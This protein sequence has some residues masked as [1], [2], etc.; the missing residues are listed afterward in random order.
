MFS[1]N[2][3]AVWVG[4]IIFSGLF[5]LGQ[6]TWPP[7][8]DND[9]DGFS[10]EG[11]ECGPVDCDDTRIYVNPGIIE[12]GPSWSPACTDG[13]DNDCD[14][15]VDGEEEDCL[16]SISC[17]VHAD[18]NDGNPCTDEW[19]WHYW[20]A[21]ICMYPA[22]DEDGDGHTP[23]ECGGDDCDDTR[24]YVNPGIIEIGIGSPA[25]TDGVDNDCDGLI[26]TEDNECNE[27][28]TCQ[29]DED[30]NDENPC[31]SEAC[32]WW[33][34]LGPGY[35][36]I[37]SFD[38]D[39]D[40]HL[41][42]A[43]G[44]DDCDDTNA[45]VYPNAP[46]LC[47]GV[48][49]QCPGDPGYGEVDEVDI[50]EDGDGFIAEACGGDD[51]DDTNADIHPA[52]VDDCDNGIDD[53]CDGLVDDDD[54][55]DMAKI[56]AGCFDM[57]DSSDG[58]NRS[59]ECPVHN[60]CISAFE[61]DVH[62]VTNAEVAACVAGGGCFG[63]SQ[64]FSHSRA[65][66]YGDPAYD[67]F[68][69]IYMSWYKAEE[70]CAWA[71]KRLPTEA[72]WEYAARGGL[73][74]KRYPRG[75][76]ISSADANFMYSGDPWDNDTSPVEYYA[77]NGYG[78]YDMAGNVWE[79]VNDWWNSDYYQYCVDHGIVNDPPGPATGTNRVS[80]SGSWGQYPERLSV[81]A[82]SNVFVHS[83]FGYSSVGFRCAR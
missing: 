69:V 17:D 41:P 71:G 12:I 61:M 10:V 63:P 30:C 7:C 15:L 58:C 46:E 81:A 47:D 23:A 51:C 22:H 59:Y 67:D 21:G 66:Y 53:D 55:C 52:A 26:D 79:W 4:I 68:P 24:I 1:R 49:N 80:R 50:D 40:G 57:G 36:F 56:P 2:T 35:C 29:S 54:Y 37:I 42:G 77:P 48:D 18:C 45:D 3:F 72:E 5:L 34:P 33:D 73:S 44:G 64:R 38:G 74:G 78:L 31:T 14:G 60:V 25:C 76:T 8:T 32:I 62:E 65:T 75:D 11:G 27:A 16:N 39:L 83:S 82:R 9:N 19:C 28:L 43:C 6:D 13:V 20:G 70:Y